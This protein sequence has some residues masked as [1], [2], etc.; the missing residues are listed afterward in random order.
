MKENYEVTLRSEVVMHLYQP[1]GVI[2]KAFF[3][4]KDYNQIK[5]GDVVEVEFPD[6][7]VTKGIISMVLYETNRLPEEFQKK[8]EPTTR[9]INAD[10]V[11]F[12]KE[13]LKLWKKYNKLSVIVRKE[14]Y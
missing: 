1:K 14:K 3:Q 4:Q 5:K 8:F 11:P 10:I 7:K 13:D 9:V 2:V 6:G 12:D